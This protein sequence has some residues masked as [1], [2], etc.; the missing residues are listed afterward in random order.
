MNKNLAQRQYFYTD[1]IKDGIKMYDTKVVKLAKP[2]E[3]S[4]QEIKEIAVREFNIFYPDGDAFLD[5]GYF[6]LSKDRYK[7][8]SF[9]LHQSCERFYTA[10]SLV[11]TNYRPKSHRLPELFA[12]VKE[13]SR[14]LAFVFPQ[15]TDFEKRCYDLICRA[16]IEARYNVDFTITKEELKYMLERIEVLKEI[17]YRVCSEKIASYDDILNIR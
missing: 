8:G 14:D 5:H 4:F 1:V 9:D 12:R 3:L 17:T 7:I 11:F 15:N 6:D 10:I 16:Y 13:Y 2:G